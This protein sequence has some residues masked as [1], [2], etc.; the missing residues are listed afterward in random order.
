M[1]KRGVVVLGVEEKEST[2]FVSLVTSTTLLLEHLCDTCFALVTGK[3]L[4]KP[5]KVR[6]F[7]LSQQCRDEEFVISFMISFFRLICF[8][9][10]HFAT[11]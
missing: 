5:T 4:S 11:D 7:N 9:G 2:C 6:I 1:K 8:L 3:R 10:A